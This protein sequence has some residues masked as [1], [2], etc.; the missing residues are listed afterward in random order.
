MQ[1]VLPLGMLP[2]GALRLVA[3]LG[4]L[5]GLATGRGRADARKRLL[6]LQR[7][8]ATLRTLRYRAAAHERL[9]RV[10]AVGTDEVEY[11]HSGFPSRPPVRTEDPMSRLSIPAKALLRSAL[12]GSALLGSTLF[13]SP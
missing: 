10:L 2:L 11:W 7:L 1:L 8:A 6:L 12:T 13:A 3:P 9:E 5:H 4:R